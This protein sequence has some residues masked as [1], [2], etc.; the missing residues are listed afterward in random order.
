MSERSI[1]GEREGEGGREGG[2]GRGERPSKFR[3]SMRP[4]F[5][6]SCGT[7]RSPSPI[8]PWE[9]RWPTFVATLISVD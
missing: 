7:C 8:E 9:N 3:R 2:G 1:E 6:F 4:M 5:S